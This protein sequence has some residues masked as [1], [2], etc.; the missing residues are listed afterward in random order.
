VSK[1]GRGLAQIRRQPV[2]QCRPLQALAGSRVIPTEQFPDLP[3]D[4]G[5]RAGGAGGFAEVSPAAIC[6]TQ[7][8]K[9]V[10]AAL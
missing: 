7:P 8:R 2:A 5:Q 1:S 9:V 10:Q 6:R 4:R 3:P